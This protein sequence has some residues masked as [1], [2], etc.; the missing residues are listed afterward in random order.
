MNKRTNRSNLRAP[1][2]KP[3][4][5]IAPSATLALDGDLPSSASN[6]VTAPE[7]LAAH[8]VLQAALAP[9]DGDAATADAA[10]E[11]SAADAPEPAEAINGVAADH[12]AATP[13]PAVPKGA[14]KKP[15]SKAAK[16]A[17]AAPAVVAKAADG[18]HA[19]APAKAAKVAKD[20]FVKITFSLPESEAGL[21][22]AMKK[23]HLVNGKALKKSQLLRAGLLA[24]ADL[25]AGRLAQL[26]AHLP[27]EPVSG[28]KKK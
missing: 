16:P 15:A 18:E 9:R 5:N 22:D 23:T 13:A 14:I 26:V 21:L 11:A 3:T 20:K 28:K 24:L 2:L 6:G 4:A 1:T 27:T 7:P 10:P 12:A 25:E 19:D 17:K 8:D